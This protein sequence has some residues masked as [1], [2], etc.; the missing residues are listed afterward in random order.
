MLTALEDAKKRGAKAKEGLV[1]RDIF[2][3]KGGREENR[4]PPAWDLLLSDFNHEEPQGTKR[5]RAEIQR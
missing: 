5:R 1:N 4:P 3:G 2:H